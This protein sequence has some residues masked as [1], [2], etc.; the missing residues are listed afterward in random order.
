MVALRGE[1]GGLRRDVDAIWNEINTRRTGAPQPPFSQPYDGDDEGRGPTDRPGPRRSMGRDVEVPHNRTPEPRRNAREEALRSLTSR[2]SRGLRGSQ[3]A[4]PTRVHPSASRGGTANPTASPDSFRGT[5][6]SG[7]TLVDPLRSAPLPRWGPSQVAS[8]SYAVS[9]PRRNRVLAGSETAPSTSAA[10][11]VPARARGH[12]IPLVGRSHPQ[13]GRPIGRGSSSSNQAHR[14]RST[15]PDSSRSQP[16][17][18]RVRFENADEDSSD[19]A[20]WETDPLSNLSH[21]LPKRRPTWKRELHENTRAVLRFLMHRSAPN[22]PFVLDLVPTREEIEA[23]HPSQGRCCTAAAFKLDLN[24]SARSKWNKSCERVYERC[25]LDIGF[26]CTDTT[27]IAEAFFSHVKYL[28]SQWKLLSKEEHRRNAIQDAR[29]RAQRKYGIW[30]RRIAAALSRR[31]TAHH[32]AMI[33]K[34]GVSVMSSDESDHDSGIVRYR[35]LIHPWRNPLLTPWFRGFDAIHWSKRYGQIA[36]AGAMR[37]A[38]PR[39][40]VPS[41]HRSERAHIPPGHPSNAYDPQLVAAMTPDNIFD[42]NMKEAYDFTHTPAVQEYVLLIVLLLIADFATT[43]LLDLL[44]N[45]AT[46]FHE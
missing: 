31:D 11:P 16:V 25:F 14:S 39:A 46:T 45:T 32:A 19:D 38:P 37:G 9:P 41:G 18:A 17:S 44:N 3:H 27:Q 43:L 34:L 7:P 40:R 23:W 29:T 10:A 22:A 13:T 8:S 15:P 20:G 26:T 12:N 1:V 5:T 2:E 6:S 24:G 30:D 4:S 36:Q 33:H 21:V 28:I 42:L 35:I